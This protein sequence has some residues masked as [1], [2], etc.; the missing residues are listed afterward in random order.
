MRHICIF[1]NHGLCQRVFNCQFLKERPYSWKLWWSTVM[2]SVP[3][4]SAEC[5][6]H[7]LMSKQKDMPYVIN[8]YYGRIN[9]RAESRTKGF[10][11][12]WIWSFFQNVPANLLLVRLLWNC[13]M[14]SWQVYDKSNLSS[15]FCESFNGKQIIKTNLFL[16]TRP[17]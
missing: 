17:S 12:I 5:F 4:I 11:I 14:F 15:E 6:L 16:S 1:I 13:E 10:K 9:R 7:F 8:P 2:A 3:I